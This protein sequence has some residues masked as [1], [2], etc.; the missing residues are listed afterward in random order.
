M[1]DLAPGNY[2]IEAQ[3]RGFETQSFAAELAPS[4]QAVADVILRVGSAAQTVT[5]QASPGSLD[6]PRV[7]AN[8]TAKPP[9]S[10]TLSRFEL[11]TDDGE[12]WTS[13]DGQ[14]WAHE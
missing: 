6:S 13:T 4:Q 8:L 3:A 2:R 9:A 5:I 10:Q 7:N 11:T 14:T 1:E 12:R